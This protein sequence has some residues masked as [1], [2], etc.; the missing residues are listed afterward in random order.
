MMTLKRFLIYFI[1]NR[2]HNYRGLYEALLEL[3]YKMHLT[4]LL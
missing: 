3:V 1:V 4:E 2:Y